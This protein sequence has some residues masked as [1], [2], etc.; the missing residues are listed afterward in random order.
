MPI[1]IYKTQAFK[2]IFLCFEAKHKNKLPNLISNQIFFNLNSFSF[3]FNLISKLSLSLIFSFSLHPWRNLSQTQTLSKSHLHQLPNSNLTQTLS[4][5]SDEV[6]A[7]ELIQDLVRLPLPSKK[8][9][10]SRRSTDSVTHHSRRFGMTPLY[11][12]LVTDLVLEPRSVVVKSR[13]S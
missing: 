2:Q 9:N 3:S 4:N 8:E 1:K 10:P 13:W 7:V 5:L 11:E 12:T 6:A